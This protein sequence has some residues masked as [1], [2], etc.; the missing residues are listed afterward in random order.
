[1]GEW[2]VEHVER[3]RERKRDVLGVMSSKW[4]EPVGPGRYACVRQV[5]LLVSP[6]R[7]QLS[8]VMFTMV[9]KE[10]EEENKSQN[11]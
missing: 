8:W 10:E 11:S 2:V 6:R 4:Y 3:E 5:A 9:W 7:K 1:V